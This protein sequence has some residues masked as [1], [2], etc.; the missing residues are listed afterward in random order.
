MILAGGVGERLGFQGIKLGIFLEKDRNQT[1]LEFYIE[2]LYYM[3]ALNQSRIIV[4]IMVSPK[5][6]KATLDLM[7]QLGL[8]ER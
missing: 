5:T 1:L 2:H 3:S 7:K 4:V 6:K 8:E